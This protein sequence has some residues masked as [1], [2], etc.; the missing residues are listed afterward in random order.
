MPML[1]RL[2]VVRESKFLTQ[3]EL[4][5]RAGMAQATIARLETQKQPA[6]LTTVRKLA[7]A[8]GVEPAVLMEGRM[9]DGARSQMRVL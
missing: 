2:R 8:L 1:P 4:A 3:R 9:D 5:T 7:E 6:R